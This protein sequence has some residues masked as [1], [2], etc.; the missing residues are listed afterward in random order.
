MNVLICGVGTANPPERMSQP[1]VY[2]FLCAHFSLEP[3]EHELYRRLLLEGPIRG[4][5]FSAER[6]EELAQ[7]SQGALIARFA[8]HGRRLAAEAARQALDRAGVTPGEIG[9]VVVNTCTGYLCPG[10]TSTL[11][12]DLELPGD[13][14]VADLLGMGCGGALPNLETA[15]GMLARDPAR[16]V[17]SV[18]VEV[19][20][21][22]LFMGPDPGLV[23][24]NCIFG[25]G[26]AAAVL[27][28]TDGPPAPGTV[29]LVEF[30]SGIYPQYRED[31]RY[32]WE[33][34][35]LRNVLTRYVPAIGA[36]TAQQVT[37]RLLGRLGRGQDDVAHWIVHPGGTEILEAVAE[38]MGLPPGALE[39]S[40]EVFLQYGNMSSPSVLFVL[41]AVLDSGRAQA[42]D[43]AVM[44]AFGAGFATHAV[45]L[46]FQ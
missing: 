46:A 21:A 31:L 32:R 4:R 33:D 37:A 9:G 13:V 41:K 28:A 30:A 16:P 6:R 45:A 38:R 22:T 40:R 8:H 20:S 35:R 11:V 27:R 39:P 29:R 3:A 42:G 1:E 36:R 15:C 10:L 26:A 43:L 25:D 24:S 23:V 14:R 44:L 19:C 17:L 5:H 2:E 34:G 12:E 18:A 7:T